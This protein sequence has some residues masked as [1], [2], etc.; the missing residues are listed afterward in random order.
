VAIDTDSVYICFDKMIE[1]LNKDL[2]REETINYLAKVCDDDGPIQKQIEKCYEELCEYMNG[3]NQCMFMKRE[4]IADNG[5]WTSKKRYIMNVWDSEGIRYKEPELKIVGLEAIRSS[6]PTAF[7]KYIRE[8]I[9]IIM[10]EDEQ[11]LQAYIKTIKDNLKNL[12]YEELAFPRSVSFST[13]KKTAAGRTYKDTYVS[14]NTIYKKG[15]PIQV[16]GSLIYNDYLK[17]K[18]LNLL[19]PEIQDGEKIKYCYLKT[20]NPTKENVIATPGTLPEE[21]NLKQYIDYDLQ[22]EK[23][24]MHPITII[25]DT[26]KWDPEKIATLKDFFDE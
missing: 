2:T 1:K 24:F 10:N 22:F 16:R 17:Q 7:R 19:Y 12:S 3:Y 25:L 13:Y 14:N 18:D 23:G 5:L 20:P 15:S 6:T 21:F 9:K 8:S 4:H 26:I 11:T